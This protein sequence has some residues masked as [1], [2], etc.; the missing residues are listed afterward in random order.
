MHRHLIRFNARLL[1]C[2]RRALQHILRL[3]TLL[4]PDIQREKLANIIINEL[5]DLVE[6][7][8]LLNGLRQGHLAVTA[9]SPEIILLDVRQIMVGLDRPRSEDT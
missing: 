5:L 4:D 9:L 6:D 3:P 8:L 7:D 2:L 1:V